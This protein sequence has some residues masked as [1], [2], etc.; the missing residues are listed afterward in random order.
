MSGKHSHGQRWQR[1][2]TTVA[3]YQVSR[4]RKCRPR[5]EGYIVSDNTGPWNL[6]WVKEKK[7]MRCMSFQLD[8]DLTY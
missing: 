2:L 1:D 5:V 7:H 6:H 4:L 8:E 3:V